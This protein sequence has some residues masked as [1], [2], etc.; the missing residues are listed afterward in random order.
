MFVGHTHSGKTTLAKKIEKTASNVVLVD[1]DEIASFVMDHYPA[2]VRSEH[3]KL[4]RNF[5]SPNLKFLLWKNVLGFCL[6]SGVNVILSNGNLGKDI[7]TLIS[8]KA[9]SKGYKLITVYI[10]LPNEAI[11]GRIK[12]SKK[13]TK[14]FVRSKNWQEIFDKQ[15]GYAELPPSK[16]NTIYF[17]INNSADYRFVEKEIVRTLRQQ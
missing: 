11:A 5:K 6:D 10:N 13:C 4:K 15:K 3:N 7:R 12:A 1:T 9:K 17:E 14:M 2:A 8:R 16:R